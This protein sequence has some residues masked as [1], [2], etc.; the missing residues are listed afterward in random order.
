M[1]FQMPA[2]RKESKSRVDYLAG[3]AS[4]ITSDDRFMIVIV[5]SERRVHPRLRTGYGELAPRSQNVTSGS[6]TTSGLP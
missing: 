2:E 6:L 1:N 5:N 4:C 3:C